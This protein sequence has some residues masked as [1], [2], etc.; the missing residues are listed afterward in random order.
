M[1]PTDE[2]HTMTLNRH[3]QHL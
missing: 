3:P 2:S 1:K